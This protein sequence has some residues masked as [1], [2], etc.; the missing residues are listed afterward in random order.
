MRRTV[1]GSVGAI[2][3]AAAVASCSRSDDQWIVAVHWDHDFNLSDG[4]SS[5]DEITDG[6]ASGNEVTLN[7]L[8]KV[9]SEADGHIVAA[10][11]TSNGAEADVRT[12]TAADEDSFSQAQN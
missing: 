10:C 3:L 7:A 11:Y 1:G 8:Y 9:N 4:C 12:M 6:A 5:M 2:V